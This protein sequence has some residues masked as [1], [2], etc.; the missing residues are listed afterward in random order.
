MRERNAH[1]LNNGVGERSVVAHH[2][3]QSAP[4][5]KKNQ[6]KLK[7]RHLLSRPPARDP[8]DQDQKAVT[9]DCAEDRSHT[10]LSPLAASPIATAATSHCRSGTAARSRSGT[11]GIPLSLPLYASTFATHLR[12][13]LGTTATSCRSRCARSRSRRGRSTG[14][15]TAVVRCARS[16]VVRATTG[17]TNRDHDDR[18]REQFTVSDCSQCQQSSSFVRKTHLRNQ[19]PVRPRPWKCLVATMPKVT[20]YGADWCP[21]TRRALVHLERIGV[22]FDYVDV[23]SDPEASAWVKSQN[24]ELEAALA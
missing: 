7:R 8:D 18:E 22:P 10:G 14:A 9:K 17:E 23:E 4:A 6:Y 3:G 2:G 5:Y 11:G 16:I 24:E 1:D 12:T 19:C 21:L 13:G 15:L 20:V